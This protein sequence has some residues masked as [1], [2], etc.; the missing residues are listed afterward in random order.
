MTMGFDAVAVKARLEVNHPVRGLYSSIVAVLTS[1]GV[2]VA[3]LPPNQKYLLFS[4][5]LQPSPLKVGR[6]GPTVHKSFSKS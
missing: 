6:I 4:V 5:T 1:V 2:V 3:V